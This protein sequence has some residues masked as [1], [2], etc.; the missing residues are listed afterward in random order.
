[1]LYR[2]LVLLRRKILRQN[3]QCIATPV[4]LAFVVAVQRRSQLIVATAVLKSVVLAV[5][6]VSVEQVQS[7][8]LDFDKENLD[9]T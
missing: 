3:S 9:P 4:Y 2:L 5:H 6:T 1:M 7:Q 8:D